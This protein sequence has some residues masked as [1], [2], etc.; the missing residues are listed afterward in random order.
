MVNLEEDK[1]LFYISGLFS[2]SF[3]LTVLFSA[4]LYSYTKNRI[5]QVKTKKN[6]TIKVSLVELPP[7]KKVVKVKKHKKSIKKI[8]V[9]KIKKYKE[10]SKPKKNS[11]SKKNNKTIKKGQRTQSFSS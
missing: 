7:P 5:I 10:T 6:Q 1:K 11:V 9:K 8:A 4:L 2:I 3:F